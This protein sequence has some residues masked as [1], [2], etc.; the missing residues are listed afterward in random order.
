MSNPQCTRN[1]TAVREA[2]PASSVQ[3]LP[4]GSI[5]P[6]PNQPR[7]LFD[8]DGLL[9]LGE[10]IRQHGLLQPL[11]VRPNGQGYVIIAGERRWRACGEIGLGSVECKVLDVDGIE[12][13]ILSISENVNRK[14]MT[15]IEEA[16]A[17]REVV[18]AGRTIEQVAEL[19][20][21]TREHVQ[22]RIDLLQLDGQLQHLVE[23]GH[24]G[25]GLAW[26]I[27]RVS[28][29]GQT[30]IMR[31]LQDGSFAN[32]DEAM[33]YATAVLERESQPDMFA[34]QALGMFDD[35]EATDPLRAERARVNRT[36]VETAWERV[37]TLSAKL[38]FLDELDDGSLTDALDLNV[39]E[40][41]TG[42]A[43]LIEKAIR[44]AGNRFKDAKVAM[45]AATEGGAA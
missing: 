8:K 41:M 32:D 17:Y 2:E 44:R 26:Y 19:F 37:R 6:N 40:R 25:E 33:R 15:P 10:S 43:K 45:Q 21:K 9:E 11:V 38:Q 29:Q 42:E 5:K 36:R 31:K 7:K 3:V 18:A 27:A 14:D 16:N 39:L 28:L 23:R 34:E 35:L 30:E 13:F 20:G 1:G 12:A 24:L 4:L 22:Y